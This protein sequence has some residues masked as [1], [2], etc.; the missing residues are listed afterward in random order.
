MEKRSDALNCRSMCRVT[1][2][3]TD[4]IIAGRGEGCVDEKRNCP[5]QEIVALHI[6]RGPTTGSGGV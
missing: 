3:Q 4:R 5:L 2:H 6:L 1:W